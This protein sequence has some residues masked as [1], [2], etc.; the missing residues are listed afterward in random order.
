MVGHDSNSHVHGI[1]F[2]AVR[3]ATYYRFPLQFVTW[4]DN[5]HNFVISSL[6]VPRLSEVLWTVVSSCGRFYFS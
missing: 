6:S 2:K 4:K 1:A 5:S 3:K